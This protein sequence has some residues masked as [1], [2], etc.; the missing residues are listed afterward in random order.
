MM[1]IKMQ[2]VTL[3]VVL[4]PIVFLVGLL[5]PGWILFWSKQPERLWASTIGVLMFMASWTAYS[6]LHFKHKPEGQQR[7]A[8]SEMSPE[9]SNQLQLDRTNP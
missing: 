6:E 4:S 1:Q 3:F 5:K 7:D 8:R 2:L 9:D